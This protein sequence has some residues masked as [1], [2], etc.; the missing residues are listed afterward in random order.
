MSPRVSNDLFLRVWQIEPLQIS[1]FSNTNHYCGFRYHNFQFSASITIPDCT[2]VVD[3]CKEKQS[4]FD[5]IN[6]MP[7]LLEQFASQ[8]S[9]KQRRGRSGRVREGTC[10][11]LISSS[12]YSKLPEHGEPEIRRCALDQSIL[13]LLFIGLENG[14][15]D[16]LNSM[17]DAPSKESIESSFL[18]LEKIGAVSRNGGLLALTPLGTHLAGIPAPPTVGKFA[19]CAMFQSESKNELLSTGFMYKAANFVSFVSYYFQ[20]NCLSWDVSLVAEIW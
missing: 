9:L 4:S 13:S 16:F 11:K 20:V 3:T 12:L 10:Y 5:P 2:I 6:R 17:L 7:L 8:D 19:I 15:G 1:R 18:S 14:S